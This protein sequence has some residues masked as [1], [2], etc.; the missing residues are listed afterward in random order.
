MYGH[1]CIEHVACIYLGFDPYVRA[2]SIRVVMLNSMRNQLT[3]NLAGATMA[4]SVRL[5]LA[6]LASSS[7][8][9]TQAVRACASIV[10]SLDPTLSRG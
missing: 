1:Q 7:W 2:T 4:F 9:R 8:P 3:L 10:S 5:H 6:V